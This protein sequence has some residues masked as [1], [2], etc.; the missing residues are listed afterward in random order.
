[1]GRPWRARWRSGKQ[2]RRQRVTGESWRRLQEG[3]RCKWSLG[4]GEA[5]WRCGERESRGREYPAGGGSGSVA[6]RGIEFC[7]GVSWATLEASVGPARPRVVVPGTF[8]GGVPCPP[9]IC[10]IGVLRRVR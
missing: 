8:G 4:A 9:W 3:E 5:Q 2:E 1:M 10:R 7:R 6:V